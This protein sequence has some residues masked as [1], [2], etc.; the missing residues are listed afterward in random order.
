MTQPGIPSDD[1]DV[2]RYPSVL[3]GLSILGCLA[4]VALVVFARTANPLLTGVVTVG[5]AL[6]LAWVVR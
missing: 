4:L 2:S 3:G 5:V 6:A 1:P